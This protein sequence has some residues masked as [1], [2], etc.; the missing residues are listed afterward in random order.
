[1]PAAMTTP[2]RAARER[3]KAAELEEQ[4]KG[5]KFVEFRLACDDGDATGCHSLGEWWAL[6]KEDFGKA[7]DLYRTNC[8]ER[9]HGP[10]CYNMGRLHANGRGVE[11][12]A[13]ATLEFFARGCEAGTADAC[14]YG[15]LLLSTGKHVPEDKPRAA[16]MLERGCNELTGGAQCCAKLGVL[17]L[18]GD[19][20]AGVARDLPL[21]ARL[22]RRACVDARHAPSCSNLAVMTHRGEGV[23]KDESEARRL[24]DDANELFKQERVRRSRWG[25]RGDD[26]G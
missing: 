13:P 9:R 7:A 12:S 6:V 15:A 21:A 14:Q 10:S 17:R 16:R 1:M 23:S 4:I 25:G 11:R 26:A 24:M 20:A 3:R 19:E 2:S 22:F 5:E 8:L 18:Q